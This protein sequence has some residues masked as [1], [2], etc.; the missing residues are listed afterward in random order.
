MDDRS[1]PRRRARPRRDPRRITPRQA[2]SSSAC[3]R[4]PTTSVTCGSTPRLGLGELPDDLPDLPPGTVPYL[5]CPVDAIIRAVLEAPVGPDDVFVDLG[6]GVGPRSRARPSRER[7]AFGRRRAASASRPHGA[8][9]V[10]TPGPATGALPRRRCDH[11]RGRR[12]QRLLRLRLLRPCGAG[13]NSRVAAGG[14]QTASHRP[15][16]RGLRSPRTRRG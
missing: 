13:D 5:P 10:R 4:C 14:S 11:D 1:A 8:I 12:R 6:A 2:P 15:V 7:R 16:R 3:A 9:G